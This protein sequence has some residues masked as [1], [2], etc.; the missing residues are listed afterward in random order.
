MIRAK[1]TV[2][3]TVCLAA[4]LLGL[5]SGCAASAPAK[6]PT[7]SSGVEHPTSS[8]GAAHLQNPNPLVRSL[9]AASAIPTTVSIPAIAVSS[10]L[11]SLSLDATGALEAPNVY[12]SAGWYA[13][14]VVP[15]AIGPAIIA[16]HIDSITAPAIF[17]RLDELAKGDAVV[18]TLSDGTVEKF[19]VQKSMESP[20]AAFPT[21]AVYGN[22]P[23]PQLR[24]I[25]CG[26]AFNATTG[27][28]VDNL[29]VY[30]TLDTA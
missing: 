20:K 24:L 6:V 25:T 1:A 5:I 26:G 18:V 29:I 15:G 27:H 19:T 11:L 30:A 10:G 22:V 14:G 9:P 21:S 8:S 7:A 12:D 2:P 4:L 28:Y 17:A 13:A 23:T 16:G 3:V